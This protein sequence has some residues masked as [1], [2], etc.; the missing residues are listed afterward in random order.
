MKNLYYITI[1][2]AGPDTDEE[3]YLD[4]YVLADS[5]KDVVDV[6]AKNM[7]GDY[8]I[9]QIQKTQEQIIY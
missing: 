8:E 6:V 3:T 1:V 9:F 7:T 2:Y 5:F 4:L